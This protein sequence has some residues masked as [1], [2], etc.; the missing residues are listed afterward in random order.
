MNQLTTPAG[1]SGDSDTEER[2]SW[3]LD[4]D[5]YGEYTLTP[6]LQKLTNKGNWTKGRNIALKRLKKEQHEITAA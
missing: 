5:R 1:T 2:I 6:K 3:M 4:V